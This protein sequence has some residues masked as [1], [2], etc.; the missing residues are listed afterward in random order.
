MHL[1]LNRANAK[2]CASPNATIYPTDH[3]YKQALLPDMPEMDDA[4]IRQKDCARKRRRSPTSPRVGARP[5]FPPLFS[6]LVPAL[7]LR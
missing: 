5:I 3:T 4:R 1:P 7:S 2:A 6:V